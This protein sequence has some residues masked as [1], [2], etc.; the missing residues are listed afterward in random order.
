M[1]HRASSA[2]YAALF[3]ELIAGPSTVPEMIG[4]TGM[5]ENTIRKFVRAMYNTKAFIHIGT[6]NDRRGRPTVKIHALKGWHKMPKVIPCSECGKSYIHLL[7]CSRHP[8]PSTRP[9]NIFTPRAS[10]GMTTAYPW[11]D[12]SALRALRLHH[13]LAAVKARQTASEWEKRGKAGEV[14]RI[15]KRFKEYT[16]AANFHIKA[17]QAL[18][19]CFDIDDTAEKDAAK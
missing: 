8:T 7:T 17:V 5:H 9:T 6:D 15:Q 10:G 19:D 16:K 14:G 18:N 13:W 11:F 4:A 2:A 1:A 12:D 3:A